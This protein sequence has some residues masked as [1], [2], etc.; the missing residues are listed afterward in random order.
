MENIKVV[1][2][3]QEL[4]KAIEEKA[5]K[6]I[7]TDEKV[8][9]YVKAVKT[10]SKVAIYAAIASVGAGTISTLTIWNPI[11]WATRVFSFFSG[12]TTAV[13]GGT[14]I[15]I[16]VIFLGIAVVMKLMGEYEIYECEVETPFG[17]LVLRRK[18]NA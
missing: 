2:N 1:N 9:K 5:D 12:A 15:L 7:I 6:I 13:S 4:K 8:A 10:A 17:R 16:A 14:I 3:I 11:G 18:G